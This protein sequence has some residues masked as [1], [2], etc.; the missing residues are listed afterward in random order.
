MNDGG[1][2]TTVAPRRQ[3]ANGPSPTESSKGRYATH[4]AGVVEVS[5]A[6]TAM[7]APRGAGVPFANRPTT[8]MPL[9]YCR[10][11]TGLALNALEATR[12]RVR[13][14]HQVRRDIQIRRPTLIAV[15]GRLWREADADILHL[16]TL[17]R[18]NAGVYSCRSGIP[19]GPNLLLKLHSSRKR[20][21]PTPLGLWTAILLFAGHP[22]SM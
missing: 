21:D 5:A 16:V 4:R 17:A 1:K 20:R 22:G 12:H 11:H 6:P 18:Q 7:T 19:P 10:S 9:P 13:E 15:N 2:S 3:S 8:A 14:D